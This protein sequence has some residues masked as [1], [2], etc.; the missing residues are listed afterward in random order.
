MQWR[1]YEESMPSACDLSDS[2]NYAAKH[3]PAAYYV[4]LRADCANWDM[5]MGTMSFGSFLSDLS[6]G[7]LPA[8]SFVTPN[9]CD[10]MHDCSVATGDSWLKSWIAQIVLSPA[11]QNGTT[12]VF[13]TWDEDDD[14][15]GNHVATLV[16]SPSTPAGMTSAM[17]FNHYSLL[18]TTEQL[19]GIST[20]LGHAGDA[21]TASMATAFNLK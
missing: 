12:A 7:A 5:P 4:P 2:G 17:Q 20:F 9:L 6:S 14:S 16:A 1:S 11:Y 8:F 21:T 3:N 19:L 13:I 15:S 18:K 10:D